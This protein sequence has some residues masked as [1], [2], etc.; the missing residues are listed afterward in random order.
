MAMTMLGASQGIYASSQNSIPN[1]IKNMT[2]ETSDTDTRPEPPTAGTPNFYK[3]YLVGFVPF[4]MPDMMTDGTPIEGEVKYTTYLDGKV[5][6]SGNA[7][8][9][10]SIEVNFSV[11][12]GM[13]TFGITATFDNMESEM[14]TVEHYAGYDSPLPPANI[15]LTESEVTWEQVTESAHGGYLDLK[16]INYTVSINGKEMGSTS[17]TSLPITL[18]EAEL[19]AYKAEVTAESKGMNSDPG[20]SNIL[21]Y[22]SPLHLPQHI[23]PTEEQS[24]LCTTSGNWFFLP[25]MMFEDTSRFY[26]FSFE[27]SYAGNDNNNLTLDVSICTA[28]NQQSEVTPAIITGFTPGSDTYRTGTANFRVENPG[29]YYIAIHSS[30]EYDAA[31]NALKGINMRNFSVEDNNLS[32]ESPASARDLEAS[33]TEKGRLEAKVSF[34]MP[35]LNYGGEQLP[36]DAE[37]EAI[38]KSAD[39][40]TVAGKPGEQISVDVETIQGDNEISV[41]ILYQGHYS[42]PATTHVFTGTNLPSAVENLTATVSSDMLEMTMTWDPVT[43]GYIDGSD[44]TGGYVD[45]ATIEYDIYLITITDSGT[46]YQLYDT[47]VTDTEYTYYVEEGSPQEVVYLGVAA[48]NEAGESVSIT[49][50]EAVLGT[51]YELPIIEDLAT[52]SFTHSPWVATDI[53]G[54]TVWELRESYTSDPEEDATPI[55]TATGTEGSVGRLATPKFSTKSIGGASLVLSISE[56]GKMPRTVIYAQTYGSDIELIGEIKAD[57]ASAGSLTVTFELPAEFLDKE[58]AGIFIEPHFG[59]DNE[60]LALEEI[61]ILANSNVS[62]T[63]TDLIKVSCASGSIEISGLDGQDVAVYTIDGK[64]AARATSV[65]GSISFHLEKGIYIVDAGSRRIKATVN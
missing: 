35:T 59:S 10:A 44:T 26:T 25:P 43:T 5:Y 47:G 36:P 28:P 42:M 61:S 18:P 30:A 48:H 32:A 63:G 16:T 9:G 65:A 6:S 45:P 41:T 57:D 11:T 33:E 46:D 53:E 55:F 24:A 58:W 20:Y 54:A 27:A 39:T 29:A 7:N 50:T 17:G 2:S 37:L 56:S 14:A 52:A 23:I 22:G 31:D 49:T 1:S 62:F 40:V 3:N 64:A 12:Q 4:T 19:T 38:V 8:A 34:T 60:I 15:R 51:P 21:A 13:H